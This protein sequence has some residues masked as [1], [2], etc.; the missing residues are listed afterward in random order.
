M[1]LTPQKKIPADKKIAKPT[2]GSRNRPEGT[3]TNSQPEM[4]EQI[5][6]EAYLAWENHGRNHGSDQDHWFDAEKR[7]QAQGNPAYPSLA[8]REVLVMAAVGET[9]HARTIPVGNL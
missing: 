8:E 9:T 5:E 3:A 4:R 2:L 6:R 7:L 1:K